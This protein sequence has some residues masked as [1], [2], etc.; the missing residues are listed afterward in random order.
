MLTTVWGPPLWHSLHTI[1]FNYPVSPTEEEKREYMNFIK[2]LVYVLPCKYCRIN[3]RKNFKVLPLTREKM[4]SRETFSRY[5][6]ELHEVV[7][8]MLG[9]KSNLSYEDVRERYEH[10]RA[11]CLTKKK[12]AQKHTGCT[13]PLKGV[14]AKCILHI[15]PHTKKGPSIHIHRA[16]QK[17]R[18]T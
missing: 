14:K 12:S 6:Y 18:V 5:M 1:S 11:R 16:T 7:N 2:S 10:F 17:V 13:E 4:A 3:L 9:K 15:V 8:K